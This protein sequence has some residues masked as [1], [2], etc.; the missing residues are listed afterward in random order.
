MGGTESRFRVRV[1]EG[2][3]HLP[4]SSHKFLNVSQG[5]RETTEE[6]GEKTRNPSFQGK[7]MVGRRTLLTKRKGSLSNGV[8]K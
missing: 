3:T 5:T 2:E 4:V 8:K 1:R 7:F 6:V